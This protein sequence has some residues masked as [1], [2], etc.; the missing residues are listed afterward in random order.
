MERSR[1]TR[2]RI[3]L[4][5]LKRD[6]QYKRMLEEERDVVVKPWQAEAT[7]PDLPEFGQRALNA[8][9]CVATDAT[10]WEVAITMYE[11]HQAMDEPDWHLAKLA[12]LS[13]NPSCAAYVDAIQ[14]IVEKFSAPLIHEQ[15]EFAKTMED[16]TRLGETFF[17]AIAD[18]ELGKDN[19]LV[20]L[21]HALITTNLTAP[22]VED[23]MAKL[24]TKSDIAALS[25]KL[26]GLKAADVELAAARDFAHDLYDRKALPRATY[27][28]L[29]GLLRLC[30]GAHFCGK[31]KM[32]CE[33]VPVQGSR[34]DVCT[35]PACHHRPH[36]GA[37]YFEA[38]A[39]EQLERWAESVGFDI[40]LLDSQ[41]CSQALRDL[42]HSMDEDGAL[43]CRGLVAVGPPRH[44]RRF[45]GC[46]RPWCPR[47]RWVFAAAEPPLRRG[48]PGR[49]WSTV[50]HCRIDRVFARSPQQV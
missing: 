36:G 16:N 23:H 48:R 22:K 20:H 15:D 19:S 32:T 8:A 25:K 13:G 35:I 27:I 39:A 17:Q 21:R 46:P 3:S 6:G 30:C 14:T 7:W 41:T 9:N 45:L 37:R 11:T 42:S 28:E 31:G 2:E 4:E 5:M 29:I 47:H 43:R 49:Q 50:S 1:T 38:Q 18:T 40:A 12:A 34:R 26:A 24:L 10:E 33:A 44:G